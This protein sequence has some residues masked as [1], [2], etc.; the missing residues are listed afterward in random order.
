MRAPDTDIAELVEVR[1]QLGT[2][3][4]DDRV[5]LQDLRYRAAQVIRRARRLEALDQERQRLLALVA[6][7]PPGSA[8]ALR[9]RVQSAGPGELAQ[10]EQEI[11]AM[12]DEAS[13]RRARADALE[14]L[15]ASLSE[16]GYTVGE[17]FDTLLPNHGGPSQAVVVASPHS[18][19]HGVRLRADQ[20]HVYL[21]VVRR[22]G[23]GN[24]DESVLAADREVQ[25]R[26]CG[27]LEAAVTA[28]QTLGV[29]LVLGNEQLPGRWAPEMAAT[30]WPD[31]AEHTE[32]KKAMDDDE[33]AAARHLWAARQRPQ[34]TSRPAPQHGR[35][36]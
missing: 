30:A 13:S 4:A 2:G 12:L 18:A 29:E 26:T 33:R 3:A 5:V 17:A 34:Q 31:I 7:E 25:E 8:Q 6:H 36:T 27:D 15:H 21:S 19:D 11:V 20:D 1:A 24:G 35:R 14:A 22:A 32:S 10:L 9:R 16:L 28:P 23:T